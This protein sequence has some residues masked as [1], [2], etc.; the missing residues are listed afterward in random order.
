MNVLSG[1]FNRSPFRAK[2]ICQILDTSRGFY[3]HRGIFG[4]FLNDVVSTVTSAAIFSRWVILLFLTAC[5][6]FSVLFN[7]SLPE[8]FIVLWRFDKI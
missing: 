7:D 1:F 2:L 3:Y 6:V 4:L 5:F 8:L